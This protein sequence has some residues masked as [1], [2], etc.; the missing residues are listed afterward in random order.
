[1]IPERKEWLAGLKVG[2]EVCVYESHYG[3]T[4]HTITTIVKITPTRK[5]RIMNNS[6][7]FNED[8]ESRNG[9]YHST[10]IPSTPEEKQGIRDRNRR[11]YIKNI[12][13]SQVSQE[14]VNKIYD[15]LRAPAKPVKIEEA[16]KK[17]EQ[18]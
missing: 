2:D 16:T 4:R 14:S 1:M 8:G 5:F 7:Q 6:N 18:K 12:D 11:H 15:I 9:W 3:E 10:L 13:Y 17:S